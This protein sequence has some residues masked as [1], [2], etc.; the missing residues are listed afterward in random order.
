MLRKAAARTIED[1]SNTIGY[2][3]DAFTPDDCANCFAAAGCD[4]D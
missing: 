2:I 1:L 4:P 3:V